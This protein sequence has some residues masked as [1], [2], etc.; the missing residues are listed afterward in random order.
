MKTLVCGC[1]AGLL[2]F[3]FS[4][5]LHA[6][7]SKSAP[8]A[9]ALVAALDAAKLDSVA[10]KDPTQPDVYVGALYVSGVQLLVV[11]GK[12][13][14]P[15]LLDARLEKAEYRDVYLDLNGASQAGTKVFIEDVLADGLRARPSNQPADSIDLMGKRTVL[16]GEWDRQKLSEQEYMAAFTQADERYA[17]VLTALLARLK[18]S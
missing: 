7:D 2:A 18:K 12:Y 14:A 9:S 15:T 17:Q 3:G 5:G 8:L 13:A 1:L 10:A 11:S 6:Q 16:N 4:S